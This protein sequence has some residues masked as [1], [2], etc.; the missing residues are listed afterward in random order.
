MSRKRSLSSSEYQQTPQ[1]A[2]K[3]RSYESPPPWARRERDGHRHI[4]TPRSEPNTNAQ[5][6]NPRNTPQP[7]AQS[8]PPLSALSPRDMAVAPQ[9]ESSLDDKAPYSDLGR[10]ICDFLYERVLNVTVNPEH[11]PKYRS[12]TKI[13]VEAKLGTL[14]DFQDRTRRLY[15]PV[16]SEAIVDPNLAEKPRFESISS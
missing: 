13:E 12:D 16:I 3:R 8:N 10:R 1:P 9:L 11:G 2:K 6:N 15:L 4:L 7:P 14:L 5:Q